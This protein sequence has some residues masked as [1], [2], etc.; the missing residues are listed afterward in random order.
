MA[1]KPARKNRT[2]RLELSVRSFIKP[3]VGSLK[4]SLTIKRLK[5]AMPRGEIAKDLP[6]FSYENVE[7]REQIGHGAYGMV[8]KGKYNKFNNEVS[9]QFPKHIYVRYVIISNTSLNLR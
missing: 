8:C 7:L 2:C 1:D 3:V 6:S 4:M 9:Y 5:N